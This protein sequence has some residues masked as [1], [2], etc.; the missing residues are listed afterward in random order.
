MSAYSF[1]LSAALAGVGGVLLTPV[2]SMS[3]D[4][5]TMLGLKGFAAA[6]LGGLGHP[7]AGVICGLLLGILEQFSTWFSSVYK[8]TLAFAVV[9]VVLLARPKGLWGK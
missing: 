7:V 6:I 5:G 2:V 4:R 3:F 8:E 9:V 1:A